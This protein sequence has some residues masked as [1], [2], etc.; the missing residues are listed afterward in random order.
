MH[1]RNNYDRK[2]FFD[3]TN[4]ASA[5]IIKLS[6]LPQTL[7]KNMS[8]FKGRLL[9]LCTLASANLVGSNAPAYFAT[10]SKAKR[11]CILTLTTE[12]FQNIQKG[13]MTILQMPNCRMTVGQN[14]FNEYSQCTVLVGMDAT[15]GS[16]RTKTVHCEYSLKHFWPTVIRQL[17][18]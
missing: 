1:S 13:A 7:R 6:S 17:C 12:H 14:C 15:S 16:F 8:N 9:A 3:R 2:T 5:N 10:A 11:K 18:N 4:H